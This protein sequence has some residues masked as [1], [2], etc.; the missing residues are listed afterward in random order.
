MKNLNKLMNEC[1]KELDKLKIPYTKPQSIKYDNAK[2]RWGLCR[3]IDDCHY[4]ISITKRLS[5]DE[6]PDNSIKSVIIHE[7]IHT[8]PKCMCHTGEWK[9]YAKYVTK[10]TKY[11]IART[12]TADK[13][14]CADLVPL[15]YKYLLECQKCHAR[16]TRVKSSNFTK[17]PQLYRCKCGGAIKLIEEK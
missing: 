7:L 16:W 9:R 8:C 14:N 11:D 1:M 17:Y 2:K 13:L 6:I 4:E 5:N 10:H 12:T 15:E 3:K